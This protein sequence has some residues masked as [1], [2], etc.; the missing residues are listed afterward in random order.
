MKR[1]TRRIPQPQPASLDVMRDFIRATL[2]E[3]QLEWHAQ[4][5]SDQPFWIHL[6]GLHLRMVELDRM[7]EAIAELL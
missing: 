7:E 2:E 1:P 6:L 3:H 5:T 4:L